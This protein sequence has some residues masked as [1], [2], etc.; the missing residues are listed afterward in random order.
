MRRPAIHD[1]GLVVCF[2]LLAVIAF[3]PSGVLGSRLGA[4]MDER[5]VLTLVRA[6]AAEAASGRGSTLGSDDSAPVIFEF[7]DYECPF[8]RSSHEIVNRW[9]AAGE[10]RVVLVHL[11]LS[12]RSEQAARA[13]ICAEGAGAFPRMHD[14][15]MTN[16]EWRAADTN[17]KAVAAAAGVPA[18][19]WFT[20]CM[21]S[22]GTTARLAR[23]SALAVRWRV[24]ATP[25]FMSNH[26]RIVG[27]AADDDL[28]KLIGR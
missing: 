5:Q 1:I 3:R 16:A 21:A 9:A 23:D 22:A 26:A 25:T 12:D 19:T 24:N 27:Q 2:V 17:W 13:A 7:S 14:H 15:L 8:C 11:T 6:G 18:G 4:W 10:A 28:R 20:R